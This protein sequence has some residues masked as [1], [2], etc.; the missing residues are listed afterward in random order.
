MRKEQL[1]RKQDVGYEQEV[2]AD[3]ARRRSES[4]SLGSL[5]G[6]AVGAILTGGMAPLAVALGTGAGAYIGGKIGVGTS[7]TSGALRGGKFLKRSRKE[8][9]QNIDD[10]I[11]ANALQTAI[12]AGMNKYFKQKEFAGMHG[13][14]YGIE[15]IW[16]GLDSKSIW[17]NWSEANKVTME[18]PTIKALDKPMHEIY[19]PWKEWQTQNL[20]KIR[21]FETPVSAINP[22]PLP[23]STTSNAVPLGGFALE[24]YRR[25]QGLLNPLKKDW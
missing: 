1:R 22:V 21:G 9:E 24:K 12:T 13:I 17:K 8:L 7:G 20:D 16:E 25:R 6:F 19:D 11:T 5:L 2:A 14:D 18:I 23:G 3:A 10:S 4:G 15:N